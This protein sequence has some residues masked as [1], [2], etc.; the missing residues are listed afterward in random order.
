M[1]HYGERAPSLELRSP[2]N[3]DKSHERLDDF[4][5]L[6]CRH[7]PDADNPA[8]RFRAGLAHIENFS[9]EFQDITGPDRLRPAQFVHRQTDRAADWFEFSSDEETH[10]HGGRVP[11][12]RGEFLEDALPGSVSIEMKR[13]RIELPREIE[14]TLF[15]DLDRVRAKAIAHLQILEIKFVHDRVALERSARGENRTPDQPR[16]LSGL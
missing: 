8:I 15:R 3:H 1:R 12:A 5:A 13:L 6:I 10:A 16:K 9:F 4:A 7:V 11:S 14:D 2:A